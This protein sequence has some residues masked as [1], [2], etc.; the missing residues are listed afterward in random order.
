MLDGSALSQKLIGSLLDGSLG[1]LVI[2][3]EASD[4]SVGA[5]GRRAREGEHDALWNVVELSVGLEAD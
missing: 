1:V 4:W 2:K 3:I 5:S